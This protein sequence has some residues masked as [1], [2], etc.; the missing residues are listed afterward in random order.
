[1]KLELEQ[2]KN[3]RQ[4]LKDEVVEKEKNLLISNIDLEDLREEKSKIE[5]QLSKVSSLAH[6]NTP[7]SGK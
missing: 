3:D 7:V 5:L 2:I 4:K 1:M 6:L